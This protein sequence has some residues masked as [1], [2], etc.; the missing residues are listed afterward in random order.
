MQKSPHANTHP[1]RGLADSPHVVWLHPGKPLGP[2][3]D[4]REGCSAVAGSSWKRTHVYVSAARN[5]S[6]GLEGL[7]YIQWLIINGLPRKKGHAWAASPL[8]GGAKPTPLPL[9]VR[10]PSPIALGWPL[11]QQWDPKAKLLEK[12]KDARLLLRHRALPSGIILGCSVRMA[13]L[14]HMC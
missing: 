1:A 3:R 14:W 7:I 2:V 9:L 11:H 6:M 5:Q 13:N 8:P 4:R 12:G 10:D